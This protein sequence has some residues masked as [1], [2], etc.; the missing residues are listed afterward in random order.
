MLGYQKDILGL[1]PLEDKFAAFSW[2][3][4]VA[5]GHNIQDVYKS[6]V[7]FKDNRSSKPKV[8]I[9]NTCKGKGVSELE[10]DELCHIRSLK[11]ENI[12]LILK[13]YK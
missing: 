2:D 13:D 10:N 8:L 1:E 11:P 4:K 6:L 12:D 7:S 5:D 3:T 9:A